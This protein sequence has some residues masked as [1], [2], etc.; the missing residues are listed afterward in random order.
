MRYFL[1]E[2]KRLPEA[3]SV[4]S[5]SVQAAIEI[6]FEVGQNRRSRSYASDRQRNSSMNGNTTYASAEHTTIPTFQ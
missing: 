3:Q 1:S 5:M 2:E 4:V 6:I